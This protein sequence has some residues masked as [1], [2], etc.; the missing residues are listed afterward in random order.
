MKQKKKWLII[1]IVVISLLLIS[2]GFVLSSSEKKEKTE[3]DPRMGLWKMV[4]M[5]LNNGYEV[6]YNDQEYSDAYYY[7]EKDNV[8][9]FRLSSST[10]ILDRKSVV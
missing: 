4:H 7:F 5:K 2:V 8:T 3:T 9:I 1:G 10:V 6:N